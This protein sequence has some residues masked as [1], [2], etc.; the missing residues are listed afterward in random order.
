MP[1]E[2]AS[3]GSRRA[4]W[5][6]LVCFCLLAAT[7]LVEPIVKFP[8]HT[9]T[10]ADLTQDFALTAWDRDRRFVENRA[11]CDPPL[12]MQPWLGFNRDELRAGRLPLWNP[13]NGNGV[14]HLANFQSAVFSPF[15][16]PYYVLSFKA[17][18]IVSALL[19]LVLLGWF[20]YLFLRALEFGTWAA[21]VGG[22]A[23]MLSGKSVLLLAYPHSA[24]AVALPAA[25]WCLERAARALDSPA[26]P[27]VFVGWCAA[28]A[29]VFVGGLYAGHPEPLVFVVLLAFGWA[30]WRAFALRR[31]GSAASM[32]LLLGF[33]LA[34]V[35][36]LLVGAP[37]TLPFLEYL[38][39]SVT[40]A[41]RVP[42]VQ[43]SLTEWWPLLVFP[44]AVGAPFAGMMLRTELPPPNYEQVN[45]TY[46]GGAVLV[47]ALLGALCLRVDRRVRLFALGLAVWLVLT[48][49]VAGLGSLWNRTPV[50]GT[51]VLLSRSQAVWHFGLAALAALA[52]DRLLSARP[53]QRSRGTAATVFVL[54]SVGLAACAWRALGLLHEH[55][56]P[57]ELEQ[58]ATA[59]ARITEARWLFGATT[60]AAIVLVCTLIL[61]GRRAWKLAAICGLL[62]I[63]GYQNGWM[64]AGFNPTVPDRNVFPVT[65][66]IEALQRE[67]RGGNVLVLT[68]N[69]LPPDTNMAYGIAQPPNYDALGVLRYE[70]LSYLAFGSDGPWRTPRFASA[71]MLAVFGIEHVVAPGSWVPVDSGLGREPLLDREPLD[72][73][74]LDGTVEVRQGFLC[75]AA[76]LDAVAVLASVPRDPGTA[77]GDLRVRLLEPTGALVAEELFAADELRA[78][79]M[80][81]RELSFAKPPFR[82]QT[83][84]DSEWLTL[85]FP[86]RED[87]YR[88]R[89]TL[90]IDAPRADGVASGVVW[91]RGDERVPRFPL[92]V[93][94]TPT[95]GRIVF[96]YRAGSDDFAHVE[97][98]GALRL[99]RFVRGLGPFFAVP[100]AIECDDN[101]Q[102]A[103]AVAHG[104]FNPY[105]TVAVERDAAA[106]ARMLFPA[107][108]AAEIA[109]ATKGPLDE[110]GPLPAV[111]GLS[112]ELEAATRAEIVSRTPTEIR[113]RVSRRDRGW[114]V[115]CQ[116]WFPGWRATVNGVER[117][118]RLAN[119]AFQ[120]V[121][122]D[123]GEN[124]VVL[125][126]APN[127]WRLGLWLALGGLTFGALLA[128]RFSRA[129]APR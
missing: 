13:Y 82:T 121:E 84:Y 9:Y 74:A 18:S 71:K 39:R 38:Q 108:T 43:P 17:A 114:L 118:V 57:S 97:T 40:I 50:L 33:A 61:T 35:V 2:L 87:S 48:C 110:S 51:T 58:R 119:Y 78:T 126:Y 102:A 22:A 11:L 69:G 7:L 14:P 1:S 47:L 53:T 31:R 125:W 109:A 10:S 56:T 66:A 45:T 8:T 92:S 77:R 25:L 52:V 5:L 70:E 75:E 120:A 94:R 26:A 73:L 46:A 123:A 27:R 104:S 21:I 29:V 15:S 93:G 63:V 79:G 127:S 95:D 116:T 80:R 62:A 122:L 124:E 113:L 106:P 101:V 19:R 105:R 85:R 54:A 37:Q 24:V 91:R 99:T 81:E 60:A 4:H 20:T 96:D 76:D 112:D 89:Y 28:L 23:F 12:E 59:L 34:G 107:R 83:A 32:R 65:P 41:T 129:S 128:W 16:L 36:A 64:L 30:A 103:R 55:T 3:I 100:L 68:E 49:D 115:A 72:A 111:V 117:P 90:V 98:L 42:L 67:T 44:D 88:R 6:A 86:P